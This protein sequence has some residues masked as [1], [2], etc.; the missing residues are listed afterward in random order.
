MGS[1]SEMHSFKILG[2]Q[3]EASGLMRLQTFTTNKELVERST[4]NVVH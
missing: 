2:R 4:V 1:L 3:A